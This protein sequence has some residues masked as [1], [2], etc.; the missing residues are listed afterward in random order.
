MLNLAVSVVTSV[1]RLEILQ[2][3]IE[4]QSHEVLVRHPANRPPELI[5]LGRRRK[6]S[7]IGVSLFRW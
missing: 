3:L 1:R 6:T 7:N 5:Y 4:E 2:I